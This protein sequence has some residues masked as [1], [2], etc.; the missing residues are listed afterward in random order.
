[1]N[2]YNDPGGPIHITSGSAGN[3][4]LHPLINPLAKH[5]E[6]VAKCYY[7][8]GY[9]RLRVLDRLTIVVEQVSVDQNGTVVDS[10]QISKSVDRPEWDIEANEVS[11]NWWRKR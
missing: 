8:Y 3:R 11:S 7:D 6:M 1:M 9:T 2:H 4:E 10:Q 5:S